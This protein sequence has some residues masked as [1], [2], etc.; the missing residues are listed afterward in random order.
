MATTTGWTARL[1]LRDS[2]LFRESIVDAND[3]IIAVAGMLEGLAGA[4]VSD[5]VLVAAA[6]SASIAGALAVAGTRWAES[7]AER[8]TQLALVA[9]EERELAADPELEVAELA[10]YYESKGLDA[11][12]A[13][14]VAEAFSARDALAAQLETEHGIDE[15]MSRGR[16]ALNALVGGLTFLL[17]AL[18][19]LLITA[20][21][22]VS[23]ETTA[24]VVAVVVSL[25]ATSYVAA[26]TGGRPV[27]VTVART[28]AVGL[29]A[30]AI[31]Y[32]TGLLVAALSG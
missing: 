29:A 8:D 18:V 17:G 22:P 24:I 28:L 23:I 30:M 11:P 1:R 31:S 6:A 27:G 12:L 19:P 20:L 25:T 5:A 3:G 4:G 21:V 16:P 10:A 15:V 9:Q 13:R 32:M 7:A 14:Q 26:R 2:G